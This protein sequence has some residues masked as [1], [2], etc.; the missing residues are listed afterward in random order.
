MDFR[1]P[2][3]RT[4]PIVLNLIIINSLVFLAQMAFGGM[5]DVNWI[6]DWFA[7]HHYNADVFKPHQLITHIFMHGGFMHLL[8]NML[9]L[10]M[11]GSLMERLW[12]PKRFL[13]FY[14]K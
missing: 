1:S 4:S 8:L 12:G 13:L 14:Q 11:F 10:W 3:Q 9:G 5:N 6:N 2:F 7:L